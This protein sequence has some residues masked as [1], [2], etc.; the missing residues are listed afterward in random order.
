MPVIPAQQHRPSRRGFPPVRINLTMFVQADGS[1]G[2]H[3][4]EFTQR[5]QW[6]KERSGHPKVNGE[7]GDEAGGNK[8]KDEEGEDGL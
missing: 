3:D 7:G 4:Q 1:H 2:D 6:G 8:V 5:F